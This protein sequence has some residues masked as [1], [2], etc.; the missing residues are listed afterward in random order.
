MRLLPGLCLMM[1]VA[2]PAAAVSLGTIPVPPDTRDVDAAIE[3]GRKALLA[4]DYVEAGKAIDEALQKTAF[5]QL[6]K[7]DQFRAILL[8]SL[9]ARG[10]EDYLAAHEFIAVATGYPD[11]KAEHWVTRA[12]MASWIDNWADA[13]LSIRTVAKTWPAALPDIGHETIQWTALRMSRDKKLEADR[14]EMLNALFAAK[15]QLEWH[16]EP[17]DLWRELVL[18]ALARKDMARA[19]E[20]LRRIVDP[21]SLVRMRTDR[22]FDDIVQASPKSFDVAAAAQAQA[23]R[24]KREANANPHK[25]SPT[26][27]VHV[28]PVPDR[29]VPGRSHARGPRTG[30]D[31]EGA[32]GQ[33]RIRGPRRH[34]QLDL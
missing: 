33:A 7:S 31:R 14:L 11:A 5:V 16:S 29:R 8:A 32:Q 28:R 21:G 30:E 34:H 26:T 2:A 15:F 13:G 24:M 23:K 17:G 1:L 6:S 10:R 3:R 27:A 25:L 4:D 19:R 22:R 20:V 18:D 9:A 12:R